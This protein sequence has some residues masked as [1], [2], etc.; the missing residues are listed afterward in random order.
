MKE[1]VGRKG[2]RKGERRMGEGEKNEQG[3]KVGG[4]ERI[5]RKIRK[6]PTFP[7]KHSTF[8]QWPC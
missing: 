4:K 5:V 1:K 3:G 2:E 8:R 7:P 6:K